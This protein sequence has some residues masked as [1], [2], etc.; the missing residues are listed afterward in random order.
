[1]ILSDSELHA[2]LMATCEGVVDTLLAKRQD[3]GTK[4]IAMT[5][6]LGL[7]VRMLD[8]AARLWNLAGGKTPAVDES[9][10]DTYTD[11]IGYALIGLHGEDWGLDP[12]TRNFP[13]M[14]DPNE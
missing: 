2:R 8:K 7:A 10:A 13:R 11:T 4:N 3:Y 14:G 12:L 1:M 5:G 9:M 6:R